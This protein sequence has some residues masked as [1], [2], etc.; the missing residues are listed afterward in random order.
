MKSTIQISAAT[1]AA[2]LLMTLPAMSAAANDLRLIDAVQRQ[3]S[4]AVRMLLLDLQFVIEEKDAHID[5]LLCKVHRAFF[6]IRSLQNERILV[7]A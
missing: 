7:H 4:E 6:I 1:L 5:N 2:L 3:D